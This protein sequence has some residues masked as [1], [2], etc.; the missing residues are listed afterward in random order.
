M[1]LS[2]LK[3]W[4]FRKFGSGSF[5][6]EKPVLSLNFN[7]SIN[8]LI[9]ENDSGK[10][11]VI[12]AI[13]LLLKTNSAEW[14]KVDWNDFFVGSMRLRIE[15]RFDKLSDDEA[16]NFTEWLAWEGEGA[17]A[18]SYLV[19]F[20]DVS[21]TED[22]ILPADVRAGID[23]EGYILTAEARDKI[24]TTY[25]RPLR[26]AKNELIPKRNSRL[27]QIL[28]THKAFQGKEESH[29][30]VTDYRE[31]NNKIE[32]YFRGKDL[33]GVDLVDDGLLGKHVKD[34]ID[35]YLREFSN[36]SSKFETT[37]NSLKSILESLGLLFEDG[38]NL[39]LGSHNLLSIASE[40]LH[41]QKANWDGLRLG[42][43]EEIEAH[44]HPQV[45]LQV[46]E[47]LQLK[48]RDVQLIFTTHSPNIGSKISLGNLI[49]FQDGNAYPMGPDYTKLL[50]T[51]YKYLERFL[52]V[53]KANL[54]FAKGVILVEGWAE[55]MILPVLAKKIS[56]NLTSK[57]VSVINIGNTAFL[58]F[59]KIF[60]RSADPQMKIP[61]SVVTDVDIKPKEAKETKTV[62]KPDG[63]KEEIEFTQEE[64]ADRI[65]K[66]QGT[67]SLKYSGNVVK[68]FVSPFWTLEY[69][70]V[71]SE[72]LRKIFY[73]SVLDALLDQKKDE[74]V[75]RLNHYEDAITNLDT[76]FI[77]WTLPVDEIAFKIYDHILN[78]NTDIAGIA[79]EPISKAIIAQKFAQNL[80]IE[81]FDDLSTETSIDYLIKAIQYATS[82]I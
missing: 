52:D 29:Q 62:G 67:K 60:Q 80:E 54:F 49:I 16:K 79:K 74:G 7:E 22:K 69:C 78:G 20:L 66:A 39:G 10:T 56:V 46:I 36:K 65:E 70:I 76:H 4:N 14:I 31:L 5:D 68:T 19:V 27:S 44:L 61:I 53:T 58:R 3:L 8:V 41:L 64:I 47:T 48:A 23:G 26:D 73:K 21:K 32:A 40:L 12:D 1:Y 28:A 50:Q 2:N 45:Q 63:T 75:T 77:N 43:I 9:G 33:N 30:F 17:D 11:A 15:C 72:K 59:S 57:G 55:E 34:V 24:K 42:L 71:K 35:S 51:D 6:L 25:L 18:K 38:I 37:D 13:K 82:N 81:A